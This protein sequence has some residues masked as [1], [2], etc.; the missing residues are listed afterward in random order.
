MRKI[1]VH[2]LNAESSIQMLSISGNT[3]HFHC[4][5]FADKVSCFFFFRGQP[6][7]HEAQV[8]GRLGLNGGPRTIGPELN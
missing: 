5:F 1:L 8:A 6:H 3:I 4:S 2:N 7:V